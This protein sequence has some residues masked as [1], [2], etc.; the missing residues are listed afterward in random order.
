MNRIKLAAA[1]M[2]VGIL[3][4]LVI[5]LSVSALLA[6]AQQIVFPE[7]NG[8]NTGNQQTPVKKSNF[9]VVS[10]LIFSTSRDQFAILNSLSSSTT[11]QPTSDAPFSEDN[12]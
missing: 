3:K 5:L 7:D 2:A 10:S 4:P 11:E 6:S 8:G 12:R 9:G 1:K